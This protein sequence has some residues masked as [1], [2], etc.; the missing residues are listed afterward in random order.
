MANHFFSKIGRPRILGHR[1]VPKDCQENTSAG[2][3]RAVELGID[4]VEFDVYLTKDKKVVVFHDED[5]KR[6]TGEEGNITDMTWDQISRL[7]IQRKV[8]MGDGV[9]CE[10]EKEE[11]IPLLE[12]VLEEF[13]GKLLMNIEM[14][15]GSRH[16]GTEVAKLVRKTGT[17]DHIVATSFDLIVLRYFEEEYPGLHSGFAYDDNSLGKLGNWVSWLP[18]VRSELAKAPG[19]QNDLSFLNYVMESNVIGNLIGATLIDCEH[20]LLDSDTA[21]KFHDRTMLVGS[22]TL[23]PLDKRAVRNPTANQNEILKKLVTY[24]VDWIETDDPEKAMGMV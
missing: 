10:Y 14:K 2:F 21:R 24:E 9:V 18:E 4:G 22:Y 5:V 8:D 6:L 1:G 3:R 7:R 19:N 20:S 13:K 11:G 12:E 15:W 17:E 16:T 23:F